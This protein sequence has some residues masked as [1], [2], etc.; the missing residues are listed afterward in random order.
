MDKIRKLLFIAGALTL[1]EFLAFKYVVI[2]T[3]YLWPFRENGV[4]WGMYELFSLVMFFFLAF[5]A[6]LILSLLKLNI[7]TVVIT[8]VLLILYIY[9]IHQPYDIRPYRVL[10]RVLMASGCLFSSIIIVYKWNKNMAKHQLEN[11]NFEL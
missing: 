6:N 4:G 9:L 10:L 2:L 1:A 3:N 7:T 8:V 11:Q 5:I